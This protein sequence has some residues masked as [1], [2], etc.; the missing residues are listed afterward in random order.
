VIKRYNNI[1]LALGIP[2]IILQFVGRPMVMLG[3]NVLLGSLI[4]FIGT[5]LLMGGLAYYAMAKGRHPAWCLLALLS[6]IGLIVLACLSDESRD[7]DRGIRRKRRRREEYDED[8]D[9]EEEDNRRPARSRRAQDES[10]DEPI[11]AVTA[12]PIVEVPKRV[13]CSNCQKAL[14]IPGKLVG[15]KV[16]CPA[17]G[18][19]FVAK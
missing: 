1:S 15:K 9:D 3:G 2:G 11:E 18:K 6:I 4:I 12:E 5:G 8:E 16:K 13:S 17:C 14:R 7:V 10:D 19:S